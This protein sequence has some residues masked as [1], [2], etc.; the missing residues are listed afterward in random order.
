M[1]LRKSKHRNDINALLINMSFREN[2]RISK[3]EKMKK[4]NLLL[5][6]IA[7]FMFTLTSCTK[8][9]ISGEEV[10]TEIPTEID[11][12]QYNPLLDNIENRD[13]LEEG[14]VLG[15]FA[16]DTPF[17]L[18]VDGTVVEINT[19]EDLENAFEFDSSEVAVN[20]DF[21][22]P[23]N[24][25]FENGE[26]EEITDGEAL[27]EAFAQCIP[28]EGWEEPDTT[29]FEGIFPAFLIT[30][31]NSCYELVYPVTLQDIDGVT[32]IANNEDEFIELVSNEEFLAFV[33]PI[34]VEGE[35]GTS[36]AENGEEL[37]DILLEC[38]DQPWEGEHEGDDYDCPLNIGSIACYDLSFPVT[39]SLTDGSEV[40]VNDYEEFS[41]TLLNGNIETF[42]YP[43]TLVNIESDETVVVNNDEE[44]NNAIE[45]CWD[46]PMGGGDVDP[47]F[48]GNAII[49][50][51][52]SDDYEGN[53]Y[54]I[55]YPV[56]VTN[57]DSLEITYESIADFNA[58]F[59]TGNIPLD[60]VYPITVTLLEDGVEVTLE[61]DEDL[62]TLVSE[63]E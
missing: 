23:L 57:E 40:I 31:L 42:V 13:D 4:L 26:T 59:E 32:Y 48:G 45:E 11:E 60:L 36:T 8:E 62:A 6:I 21:V 16:I 52:A 61:N 41:N 30:E 15:C 46:G 25:T 22:Y 18:D 39:F 12:D 38:Q 2:L 33:F 3:N 19:Y 63:C 34:S 37:F 58:A 7:A 56:E 10:I 27:G 5:L 53:C 50:F 55:N 44:F 35:D 49:L 29:D 51:I 1:M 43:I 17:S 24:I 47:P 9:E 20:V 54:S 14:L 28:D